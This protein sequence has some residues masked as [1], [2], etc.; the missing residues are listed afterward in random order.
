MIKNLPHA[1]CQLNQ[2]LARNDESHYRHKNT[3]S[4]PKGVRV[5]IIFLT[6]RW[7]RHMFQFFLARN[8][9]GVTIDSFGNWYSNCYCWR[10]YCPT[11]ST[12]WNKNIYGLAKIYIFIC[13]LFWLVIIKYCTNYF[14]RSQTKSLVVK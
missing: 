12:A 8:W 3:G 11:T 7:W 4:L 2:H 5:I 10:W 6:S 9:I 13:V 14:I 1:F